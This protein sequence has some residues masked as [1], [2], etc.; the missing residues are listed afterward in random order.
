MCGFV[1]VISERGVCMCVYAG[2][3][4]IGLSDKVS[5]AQFGRHSKTLFVVYLD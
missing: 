2:L 5:D 4:K 3:L 1:T